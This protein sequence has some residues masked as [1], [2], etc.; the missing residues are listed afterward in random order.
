MASFAVNTRVGFTNFNQPVQCEDRAVLAADLCAPL[1][2]KMIADIPEM[3]AGN[4][5]VTLE[6]MDGQPWQENCEQRRTPN[7]RRLQAA[8]TT[9][10]EFVTVATLEFSQDPGVIQEALA[11]AVTVTLTVETV[12]EILNTP[13]MTEKYGEFEVIGTDTDGTIS[14]L[15]SD[16]LWSY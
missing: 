3:N 7:R 16:S 8:S 9:F 2:E 4:T 5:I 1:K 10:L 15:V 14:T 13:D 11:N 6:Q 12:I